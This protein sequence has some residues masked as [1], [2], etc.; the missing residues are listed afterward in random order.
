MLAQKFIFNTIRNG[1]ES[2]VGDTCMTQ[3]ICSCTRKRMPP[4]RFVLTKV[5][6]S[7]LANKDS[8][9][10]TISSRSRL[11][12]FFRLTS[13]RPFVTRAAT[14]MSSFLNGRF[15]TSLSRPPIRAETEYTFYE[16]TVRL[17]LA[18][19]SLLK[20]KKKTHCIF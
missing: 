6:G 5:S 17:T 12:L 7:T 16:D 11:Y 14:K 19:F 8:S 20:R 4:Q 9:F 2:I 13:A 1:C 10:T 3:T 15:M 18:Y